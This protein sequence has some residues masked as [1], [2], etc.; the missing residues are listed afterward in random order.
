M[1]DHWYDNDSTLG[2]GLGMI[3]LSRRHFRQQAAEAPY[4]K[5]EFAAWWAGLTSE[6]QDAYNLSLAQSQAV[7]VRQAPQP[8]TVAEKRSLAKFWVFGLAIFI[9][10][11]PVTGALGDDTAGTAGQPAWLLLIPVIFVVATLLYWFCEGLIEP[12]SKR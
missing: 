9:S 5:A 3:M 2:L 6:Q 1:A 7:E 10:L 12:S 11:W 8:R 4:K